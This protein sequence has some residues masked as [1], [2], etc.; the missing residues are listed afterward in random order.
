LISKRRH[1]AIR[2]HGSK[3]PR[4]KTF[5]E[6]LISGNPRAV[7]KS[8]PMIDRYFCWPHALRRVVSIKQDLNPL[9]RYRLYTTWSHHGD[10]FG[11]KSATTFF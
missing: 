6:A 4:F 1:S 10:Q 9:L 8:L 11:R 5:E 7:I 3:R 2:A